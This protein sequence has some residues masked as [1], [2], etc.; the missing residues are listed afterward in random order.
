MFWLEVLRDKTFLHL[1]P[2]FY[3]LIDLKTID[4]F[5]IYRFVKFFKTIFHSVYVEWFTIKFRNKWDY[6]MSRYCYGISYL[7]QL[8]QDV[9]MIAIN[10]SLFPGAKILDRI[11]FGEPQE[12]FDRF[13]QARPNRLG[14]QNGNKAI[15]SVD[16][17]LAIWGGNCALTKCIEN[18]RVK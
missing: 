10:Y 6:V 12:S 8:L 1:L 7:H 9:L 13:V 14:S 11:R 16:L 3:R 17:L 4:L 2:H 5:S 18:T 15:N